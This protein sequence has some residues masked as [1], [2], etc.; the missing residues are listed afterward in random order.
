MKRVLREQLTTVDWQTEI[1]TPIYKRADKK[2]CGNY[3]GITLLRISGKL[4]AR[5]LEG[6]IR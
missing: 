3:R 4:Y 5:I 2:D 1:I 6:R